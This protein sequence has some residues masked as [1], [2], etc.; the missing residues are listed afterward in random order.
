MQQFSVD[1]DGC[2]TLIDLLLRG[3]RLQY[4]VPSRR[5]KSVR[6]RI[7]SVQNYLPG[8]LSPRMLALL[9][10]EG[11]LGVSRCRYFKGNIIAEPFGSERTMI[12]CMRGHG[13]EL[14]QVGESVA[15]T[16]QLWLSGVAVVIIRHDVFKL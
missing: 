1:F 13:G 11:A 8:H 14:R 2:V 3:H 5:E 10:R 16:C 12:L 6:C 4:R 9:G 15:V 7:P